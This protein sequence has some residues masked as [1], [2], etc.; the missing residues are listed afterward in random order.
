MAKK[1]MSEELRKDVA[2]LLWHR[3]FSDWESQKVAVHCLL[4][5]VIAAA[6]AALLVL[7]LKPGWLVVPQTVYYILFFGGI[8][9][10]I[11]GVI[12]LCMG[13]SDRKRLLAAA[14]ALLIF[15][16]ILALGLTVRGRMVGDEMVSGFSFQGLRLTSQQIGLLSDETV[17]WLN[18]Y[19]RLP[20]EEQM[21][22]DSVPPDLIKVLGLYD[23]VRGGVI[24]SD[25]EAEEWMAEPRS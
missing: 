8:L 16:G 19:N 5:L 22:V 4:G 20:E 25:K 12:L 15:L 18:W 7:G 3:E 23:G 6:L 13:S 1:K 11:A 9:I 24:V 14:G 2:I 10:L 17:Q 21:A